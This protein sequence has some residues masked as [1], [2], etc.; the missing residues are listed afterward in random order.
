MEIRFEKKWK[1]NSYYFYDTYR[2]LTESNFKF[3][4][5]YD[6]R[7][8]NSIYY[9]NDFFNSIIEN[10]DGNQLKK[11]NKTQMVWF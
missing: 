1:I 7:W 8:V 2:A 6:P 9:D 10:L 5:Q 4:E 11:K 3:V